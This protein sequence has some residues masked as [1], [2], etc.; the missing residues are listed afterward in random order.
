MVIP[1]IS[2]GD[3]TPPPIPKSPRKTPRTHKKHLKMHQI[4]PLPDMSFPHQNPES[5]INTVHRSV[6]CLSR[7]ISQKVGGRRGVWRRD[8]D[9]III[10][11]GVDYI[12]LPDEC[13]SKLSSWGTCLAT[14]LR[15]RYKIGIYSWDLLPNIFPSLSVISSH[16]FDG[17]D[18][19]GADQSGGASRLVVVIEVNNKWRL[20][21][22]NF[23]QY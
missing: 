20:C 14:D 23:Q 15:P 13:T 10:V 3:C 11:R 17:P 5:R 22:F 6:S 18:Q 12:D 9:V 2:W 7:A 16:V 21:V 8:R 1:A 19:T 4:Y